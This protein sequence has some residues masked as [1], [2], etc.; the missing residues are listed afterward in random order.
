M[1]FFTK[2]QSVYKAKENKYRQCEGRPYCYFAISFRQPYVKGHVQGS[3]TNKVQERKLEQRK[4]S[5]LYRR[6]AF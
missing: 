1:L 5:A 6:G 2:I 3:K 4:I